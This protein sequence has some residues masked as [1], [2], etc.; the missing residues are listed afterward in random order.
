M[1]TTSF[2][3]TGIPRRVK[4]EIYFP[5]IKGS[6]QPIVESLFPLS[7][8]YPHW[9][10]FTLSS[11]WLCQHPDSPWWDVR[12]LLSVS[13][14]R[15]INWDNFIFRSRIL[16]RTVIVLSASTPFLLVSSWCLIQALS[17]FSFWAWPNTTSM[18][19]LVNLKVIHIKDIY[20]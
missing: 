13:T 8:C 18:S 17:I 12:L 11:S 5:V 7:T 4:K 16:K 14:Y 6:C 10:L 9:C 15:I 3:I 2:I 20:W 19:I 1:L